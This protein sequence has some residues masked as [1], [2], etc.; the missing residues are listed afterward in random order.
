MSAD[1]LV[2]A[3]VTGHER[4]DFDKR[5]VKKVLRSEGGQ[6]R[7]LARRLIARKQI[8]VP[9]AMPGKSAGV[10]QRSIKLKVSS[11]GFWAKVAPQK[12]SEM[13]AFYPAFLYYGTS[14]GLQKRGNYMTESLS[15]RR[16][17]AQ[18]AIYATLRSS[19]KPR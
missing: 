2:T 8:S 11:G 7:K 5:A 14:R 12:T 9:G 18:A 15:Q 17:A 10:L 3:T 4:I 6:I 1:F 19:L 13:K 16:P